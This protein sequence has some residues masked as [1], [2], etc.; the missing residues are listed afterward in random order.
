MLGQRVPHPKSTN[1][2][3]DAETSPRP[4]KRLKREEAEDDA[5]LSP[6]RRRAIAV[7]DDGETTANDE[8]PLE[9]KKTDLETALPDIATDQDAI[10]EYEARRAAEE[11]EE[12]ALATA[13]GRLNSRKWIR[14]KNSIYVDAFNLALETVLEDE[15]HLFDEKETAVFQAWKDLNYEAQYL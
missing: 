4:V 3:D 15:A 6:S 8:K 9:A 12:K 1:F 14:G 11:E 2:F 10:D 13:E 7:T 5:L